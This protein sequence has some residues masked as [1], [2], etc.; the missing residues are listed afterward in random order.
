[1]ISE[2]INR[3]LDFVTRDEVLYI[4]LGAFV[5]LLSTFFWEIINQRKR[6]TKFKKIVLSEL[7]D[8]R[9]LLA[10]DYDKNCQRAWHWNTRRIN[11]G[12]VILKC[13]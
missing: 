6:A 1:M 2:T 5:G 4:F 3:L 13:L 10:I 8:L 7:R 11:R 9:V 12:T